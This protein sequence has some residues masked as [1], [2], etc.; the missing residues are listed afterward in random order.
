MDAE[1]SDIIIFFVSQ[2]YGNSLT[3]YRTGELAPHSGTFNLLRHNSTL[4]K[5]IRKLNC[6]P[7]AKDR[8]IP[9]S[10]GDP[11]PAC[12]SCNTG[13]IWNG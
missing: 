10:K 8:I 1:K 5:R 13:V 12:K 9:L 4:L 7:T 6:S 2:Y 11:F 3:E